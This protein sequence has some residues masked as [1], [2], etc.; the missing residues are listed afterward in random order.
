M[1]QR[2]ISTLAILFG[3]LAVIGVLLPWYSHVVEEADGSVELLSSQRGYEGEFFGVYT[4]FLAAAGTCA[5]VWFA[6][7]RTGRGLSRALLFV[8]LLAFAIGIGLTWV[9]VQRE[10]PER[11]YA[12]EGRTESVGCACG[13]F[14]TLAG[15]GLALLMTGIAFLS[16]KT[17]YRD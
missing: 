15:C 2:P 16:P 14:I 9:D 4:V 8:A 3:I 11:T 12:T 10:L 6:A 1:T 5:L 17:P 7:A 13:M